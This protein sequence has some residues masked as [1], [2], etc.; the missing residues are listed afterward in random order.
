MAESIGI[1]KPEVN[2]FLLNSRLVST[3]DEMI[4]RFSQIK[5]FMIKQETDSLVLISVESWDMQKNPFLFI[6]I[7]FKQ[8]SLSMNY[9]IPMDASKKMRKLY[10][11]RT[12]LEILS[13]VSDIYA[14]DQRKLYSYINSSLDDVLS[15]M[16]QSYSSLFNNY[17]S[18]FGEYR[19]IRRLNVELQ[20]SNRELTS[21]AVELS[22]ENKKLKADLDELQKYSDQSLMVMIEDWIDGHSETIDLD[23]FSNNYHI[24]L[25]R[26]EQ[27]L[28]KMVSEGYLQLKG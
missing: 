15:S 23:A 28:N 12:L 18:L 1:I 7:T 20:K 22:K 21:N 3:F 24:P 19:E 6:V 11:I 10:V 16:T 25:S 4:K 26:V 27:I 9:T 13:L 5:T 8:N 17:D 2:E 14:V